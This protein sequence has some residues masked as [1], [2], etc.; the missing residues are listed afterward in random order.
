MSAP[1]AKRICFLFNH[2]FSFHTR[3]IREVE[4]LLKAG[5]EVTVFCVKSD[6][7]PAPGLART[8]RL[9]IK[10]ILK[11]RLHKYHFFNSYVP[12]VFARMLLSEKRFDIVQAN[13]P[14]TLLLGWM[15][16]RTWGA[17]LVYD[18]HEYWEA[19]FDEK[20]DHLLQD[21]SLPLKKREQQLRQL[22]R[23]RALETWML[24]RA[25]AVISV[26]DSI[27]DRL[28][29]K[30]HGQIQ[31]LIT[32]RNIAKFRDHAPQNRRIH[33][34]YN[35][36]PETQVLVYQG[37]IAETRG[38]GR[39][40]AA[41]EHL[42]AHV[43]LVMMGPV[44]PSDEPFFNALMDRVAQTPRLQ[45]RVFYKGFL[46]PNELLE[47][48]SAADLGVQPIVN[49][50][51]NHYLCLPNKIFEYIQSGLPVAVSDFPELR[52]IVDTYQVGITF[53][54]D[55]PEQMA[56][57]IA[58][59]LADPHAQA[60]CRQQVQ[61]AKTPLSWESEESRLIRLYDSLYTNQPLRIQDRP[62]ATGSERA[63]VESPAV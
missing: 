55:H 35:L 20:R 6:R 42:P 7:E 2:D 44:F 53:D 12:R 37:Q 4:T 49:C 27:C 26:C 29:D 16:A 30:A 52:H 10:P 3:V 63:P 60:R 47:W 31:R 22:E 14:T 48:T 51:L 24:P 34:H 15:L 56:E 62:P 21:T 45:G 33:E 17:K 9:N 41:M 19:Q 1:P 32:L 58:A 40:V 57:R 25:D 5:Y 13:D 11:K 28:Q 38:L 23:S 36:P 59:F 8:E 46:P 61:A 18:A 43:V 39:A 50:H 54:P